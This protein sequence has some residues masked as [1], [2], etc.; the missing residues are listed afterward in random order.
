M[1]PGLRWSLTL[2]RR[3]H[4]YSQNLH[5]HRTFKEPN[6]VYD[7]WQR[8][9]NLPLLTSH[10]RII[11]SDSCSPLLP[12]P[13]WQQKDAQRK[14]CNLQ[15]LYKSRKFPVAEVRAIAKQS[16]IKYTM[17]LLGVTCPRLEF[18]WYLCLVS[19]VKQVVSSLYCMGLVLC[20][21][22]T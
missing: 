21:Q 22:L 12:L 7:Y 2:V 9:K 8:D 16:L 17:S 14:Q 15:V 11:S 20:T 4:L 6:S 19:R 10:N 13:L 3:T 5:T 1:D 18:T